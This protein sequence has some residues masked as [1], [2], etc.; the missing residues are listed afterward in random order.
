MSE[1]KHHG[2]GQH[3]DG[4]QEDDMLQS[5][6]DAAAALIDNPNN[7]GS[8]FSILDGDDIPHHHGASLNFNGIE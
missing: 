3:D 4:H 1:W 7:N 2:Y 5:A 8:D 6:A